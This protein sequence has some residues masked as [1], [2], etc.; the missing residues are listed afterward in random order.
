MAAGSTHQTVL[1]CAGAHRCTAPPPAPCTSSRSTHRLML[2]LQLYVAPERG[3]RPPR[4]RGGW[5]HP[6]GAVGGYHQGEA[7]EAGPGI[8]SIRRGHQSQRCCT[9]E[10]AAAAGR[11]ARTP[12]M[13][14]W[15]A[16]ACSAGCDRQRRHAPPTDPPAHDTLTQLR[17]ARTCP[18][19]RFWRAWRTPQAPTLTKRGQV[20]ARTHLAGVP[21]AV[22]AVTIAAISSH[23]AAA[24]PRGEPRRRAAPG[25]LPGLM[26]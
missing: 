18:G 12:L 13:G 22:S 14:A 25:T 21:L 10:R 9:R 15:P 11:R 16:G 1:H 5:L 6:Q 8:G 19:R 17:A 26:N 20:P 7:S 23:Q 2:V 3:V 4:R 24:T